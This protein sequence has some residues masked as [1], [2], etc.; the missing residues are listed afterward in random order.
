MNACFFNITLL[1]IVLNGK[2]RHRWVVNVLNRQVCKMITTSLIIIL[3]LVRYNAFGLTPCVDPEGIWN[4]PGPCD[5]NAS[6]F[7]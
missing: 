6:S 1:H 2:E 7:F 3:L 5:M 4:P